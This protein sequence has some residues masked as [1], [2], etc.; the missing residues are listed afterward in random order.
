MN[1]KS[2]RQRVATDSPRANA[3]ANANSNHMAY[4][5]RSIATPFSRGGSTKILPNSSRKTAYHKK[6]LIII[7]VTALYTAFLYRRGQ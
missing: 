2:L 1:T 3:N 7:V 6:I 5:R 4:T